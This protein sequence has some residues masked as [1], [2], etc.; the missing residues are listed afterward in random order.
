VLAVIGPLMAGPLR[1]YRAVHM[2]TVA[3]AML[4][5]AEQAAPGVHIVESDA[6]QDLG[7]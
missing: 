7:A 5:C 6:I 1:K 2:K 4:A 3:R